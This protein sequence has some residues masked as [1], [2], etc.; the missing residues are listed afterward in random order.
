M[1]K[2][3]PTYEN[4]FKKMDIKANLSSLP[5]FGKPILKTYQSGLF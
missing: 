5:C 4:S 2:Y 3:Y 1:L